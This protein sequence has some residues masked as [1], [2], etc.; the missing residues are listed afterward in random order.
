MQVRYERQYPP[1][2]ACG[3][4]EHDGAGLGDPDHRAGEYGVDAVEL[5]GAQWRFVVDDVEALG[6]P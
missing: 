5:A 4:V 2:H 1:A 3:V 6:S